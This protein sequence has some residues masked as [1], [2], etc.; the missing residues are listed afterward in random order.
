MSDI[1]LS[2]LTQAIQAKLREA[3]DRGIE[4]GA[5]QERQRILRLASGDSS[6]VRS[7]SKIHQPPRSSGE[8]VTHGTIRPLVRQVLK[9]LRGGLTKFEIAERVQQLDQRIAQVSVMNELVRN[10]VGKKSGRQVYRK[11]DYQWSLAEETQ[12][13]RETAGIATND[14]PPIMNGTGH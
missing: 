1:D 10:E 7:Q 13:L 8:R 11:K 9:G 3:F 2:D 4:V 5:Q 14:P 6:V 12:H